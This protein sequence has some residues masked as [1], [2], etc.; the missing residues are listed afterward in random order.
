[1]DMSL[2]RRDRARKYRAFRT[3][4]GASHHLAARLERDVTAGRDLWALG[5]TFAAIALLLDAQQRVLRGEAS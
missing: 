4:C 1:M 2:F 5:D 3:L